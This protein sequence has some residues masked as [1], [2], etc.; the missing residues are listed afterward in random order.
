MEM[1]GHL[2]VPNGLLQQKDSQYALN[3]R[4]GMGVVVQLP[5]W[6]LS[7]EENAFTVLG[8]GNDSS[9]VPVA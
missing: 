1:S 3:G 8:I 7:R 4:L 5:I 9:I 2:H 6:T